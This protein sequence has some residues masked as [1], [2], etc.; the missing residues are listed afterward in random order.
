MPGL[1]EARGDWTYRRLTITSASTLSPGT[2]VSLAG[3]RTVSEYSGGQAG[4]LGFIKHDSMDSLP[5]GQ[6]IIA[7]PTPGCTAYAD[8]PTGVAASALSIGWIYGLYKVTNH[9]S[10]IT[11]ATYSDASRVV[12]VVGPIDSD[13]SRIEVSFQAEAVQFFSVTSNALG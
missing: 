11:D 13:L 1:R 4:I 12:Q 9:C 5:S 7:I 8:V 3:A 6:A 10:Y 2:A